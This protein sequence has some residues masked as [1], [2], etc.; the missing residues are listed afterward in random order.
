[1]YYPCIM[2]L[3]NVYD[4]EIKKW[5]VVI[6]FIIYHIIMLYILMFFV[7]QLI[8]VENLHYGIGFLIVFS[9]FFYF[10]YYI[11][12]CSLYYKLKEDRRD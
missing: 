11:P 4:V 8:N 9:I 3:L 5:Q 1:M 12:V 7:Q 6:S 2:V 10:V